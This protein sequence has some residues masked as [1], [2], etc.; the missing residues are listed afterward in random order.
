MAYQRSSIRWSL[1][2][3]QRG[4]SFAD[5]SALWQRAED[6]DF[7][8][9]FLNDHLYG[10][11][12]ESWTMLAAMFSRTTRILGGTLVTSNSFRH[13]TLLAKMST[14]VDIISDGRLILGL[15]TGNEAEEY[16]T[17]GL[18]FPPAG[19]RVRRLEESCQILEAAWSGQPSTL[20]GQY[21]S[22]DNATFAPRPVRQPHPI[23][24]LGAKGDQAMRVA[25]RHADEWN[26]NRSTGATR[27]FLERATRLDELCAEHGR[28]PA[29]LPR[30]VGYR[31]LLAQIDAGT[32]TFAGAV[33][34]TQACLRAGAGHVILMLGESGQQDA[35]IDFYH[36][37]FI[38]AVL[39]GID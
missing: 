18:R 23:L 32:E 21:Y 30:S 22:L 29:S 25:V 7:H 35:E 4:W 37:R 11:A 36:Q 27:D 3:H 17:Y 34:D 6:L 26:W 38:P 9:V 39:S 15:G 10:S 20:S 33:E 8:A 13:P 16:A 19:E 24:L 5:T 31:R 1:K 12:L 14:T 2:S 28:D